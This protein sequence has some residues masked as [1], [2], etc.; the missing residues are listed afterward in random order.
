MGRRGWSGRDTLDGYKSIRIDKF[1]Q[2]GSFREGNLYSWIMNWTNRGEDTWSMLVRCGQDKTSMNFDFASTHRETGEKTSYNYDVRLTK[3]VC[4]Y[5]GYRYW[6][7]C[8]NCNK[9]YWVLYLN[10]RD[11]HFYCRKCL[12]LRYDTQTKTK[13]SYA[14]DKIYPQSYEAE[15]LYKTIKYPYRNGEMTRKYKRY[16][17]LALLDRNID[18]LIQVKAM[19]NNM[20]KLN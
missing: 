14:F 19:L 4:N 16:R 17:R 10:G 20:C 11:L 8:P 18:D 6:F 2:W 9:R 7:I 3:T 15:K 13:L 5:W 12:N 1:T